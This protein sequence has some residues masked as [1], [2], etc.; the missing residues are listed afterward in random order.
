LIV[1][2]CCGNIVKRI[3]NAQRLHSDF[4]IGAEVE[5]WLKFIDEFV[6]AISIYEM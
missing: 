2:L 1:A 4:V 5:S 6:I 3:E